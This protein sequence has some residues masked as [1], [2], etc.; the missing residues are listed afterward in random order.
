MIRKSVNFLSDSQ[1]TIL[2]LILGLVA[3]I[4]IGILIS[5]YIAARRADPVL[6]DENGK[7]LNGRTHH[8]NSY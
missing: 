4:F 8:S 1:G 2:K 7:P 5:V 6:L 3:V